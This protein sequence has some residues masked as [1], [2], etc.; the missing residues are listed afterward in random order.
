MVSNDNLAR[1]TKQT[2]KQCK[3]RGAMALSRETCTAE[4]ETDGDLVELEGLVVESQQDIE[5]KEYEQLYQRFVEI[6]TYLQDAYND[7]SMSNEHRVKRPLICNCTGSTM[8][9]TGFCISAL[10]VALLVFTAMFWSAFDGP[11]SGSNITALPGMTIDEEANDFSNAALA[12]G[13][14]VGVGFLFCLLSIVQY[15][16]CD[17]R[18]YNQSIIDETACMLQKCDIYVNLDRL[19]SQNAS[20][21]HELAVFVRQIVDNPEPI[22][23]AA[24]K[25]QDQEIARGQEALCQLNKLSIFANTPLPG[26]V[27]VDY[28]TTS[29]IARKKLGYS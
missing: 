28:L 17:H 26:T 23:L 7:T 4:I 9:E 19:P 18:R 27:V 8:C 21:M 15:Y 25:R 20:S 24:N 13:S 10:G 5:Q 2:N 6:N 29:P 16:L 22:R 12:G 11:S 3:M 1:I 14:I